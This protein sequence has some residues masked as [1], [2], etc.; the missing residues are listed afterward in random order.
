M[1]I[2]RVVAVLRVRQS[3]RRRRTVFFVG[4]I[5][6]VMKRVHACMYLKLL[7][8]FKYISFPDEDALVA[9]PTGD[10]VAVIGCETGSRYM[11]GVTPV[12]LYAHDR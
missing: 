2:P 3:S 10:D 7:Q 4:D 9:A 12:R 11:R 8:L 5:V 6:I 1:H